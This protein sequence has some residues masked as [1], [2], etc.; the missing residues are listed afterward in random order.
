MKAKAMSKNRV[1][2]LGVLLLLALCVVAWGGVA[3][4]FP[5]GTYEPW[6]IVSSGGHHAPAG[7]LVTGWCHN[8]QFTGPWATTDSD[9]GYSVSMPGDDTGV[10]GCFITDTLSFKITLPGPVTLTADQHP[11]WSSSVPELN[12]TFSI[13]AADV[14]SFTASAGAGKVAVKWQTASEADLVGF[15]L[16]RGADAE[17]M[18]LGLATRL[19]T[20]LI[21]G[22]ASGPGQGAVYSYTDVVL[23]SAGTYYYWIEEVNAS[24]AKHTYG[25]VT[26][27]LP[28]LSECDGGVCAASSAAVT[29]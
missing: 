24:G 10:T 20:R 26:A 28:E 29:H 4:A 12:L 23:A 8:L 9:G 17:G 1:R 27:A 25:P 13:L 3:L 16:Y 15:N 6:G 21:P 2:L 22:R 19:N 5:I 11:T 7:L 18:G 14:T